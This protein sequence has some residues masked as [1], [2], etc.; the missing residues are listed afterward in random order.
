MAVEE[1]LASTSNLLVYS[2]MTVYTAALGAFALDLA[3]RGAA[4]RLARG[5]RVAAARPAVVPAGG[6]ASDVEETPVEPRED[7]DAAPPARRWAN[8]GGIAVSL[9]WLAFLLHL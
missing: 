5:A 7:A 4:V 2:A 9:T 6:P 8:A 1:T 3:G